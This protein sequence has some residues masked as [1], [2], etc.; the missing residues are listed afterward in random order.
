MRKARSFATRNAKVDAALAE[1]YSLTLVDPNKSHLDAQAFD[2]FLASFFK[3]LD[4]LPPGHPVRVYAFDAFTAGA[5]LRWTDEQCQQRYR[6]LVFWL[7]P[8]LD[9][10]S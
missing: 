9:S 3:H 10:Y 6:R 1:I 2:R 5:H 8:I 7:W 4:S